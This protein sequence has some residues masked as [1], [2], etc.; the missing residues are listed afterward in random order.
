MLRPPFETKL[1]HNRASHAFLRVT[2]LIS[3]LAE[4]RGSYLLTH[5]DPP[6]KTCYNSRDEM[7]L[8]AKVVVCAAATLVS[9]FI[10][11]FACCLF[12]AI[13]FSG[14]PVLAADVLKLSK[15]T[16]RCQR[17]LVT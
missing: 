15:Q 6:P 10:H 11:R 14:Q 12:G 9:I 13:V 7:A 1:E 5:I 8:L 4:G 3:D 16:F 17:C 2:G